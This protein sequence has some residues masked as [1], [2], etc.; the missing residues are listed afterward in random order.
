[1]S[2]LGYRL[3]INNVTITKDLI[4]KGT[5]QFSKE[6]RMAASWNDANITE[7]HQVSSNRKVKIS[8]NIRERDL[9]EQEAIKDIFSLSEN[10]PVTYWDDYAC[11]YKSSTFYMDAPKITHRNTI[12]G[13]NY[14]A[15]AINL[16]EY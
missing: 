5:Y 8:F 4:Q 15:T 3:I 12:G 1:M 16:T 10:I 11:E 6:K 13:I 9:S 7:H 2:Y 14:N